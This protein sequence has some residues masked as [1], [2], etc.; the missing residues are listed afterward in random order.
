MTL[1]VFADR[2]V[3]NVTFND[4]GTICMDY[5]AGSN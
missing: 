4:D 1:Q 5:I 2:N 3:N